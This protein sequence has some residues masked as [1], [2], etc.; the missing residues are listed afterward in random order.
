MAK[1]FTA[2]A[3]NVDGEMTYNTTVTTRKAQDAQL[4]ELLAH[5]INGEGCYAR[6]QTVGANSWAY[7][8]LEGRYLR[9]VF[10]EQ[11]D[12]IAGLFPQD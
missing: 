9:Q 11:A 3:I 12:M 5:C 7:F 1:Q 6:K 10:K 8:V 4:Q 2:Q